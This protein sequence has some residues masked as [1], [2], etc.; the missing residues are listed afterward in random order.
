[1]RGLDAFIYYATAPIRLFGRSRAFRL[2]A[3]AAIILIV[4]FAGANWAINRIF[5]PDNAA[6]KAVANLPPPPPLPAVARA[7]QVIAPV[8]IP[9][10]LIQQSLDKTA[11]REFSGKGSESPL[12]GLLTNA[13]VGVVVN[14][15]TMAVTGKPNIL[16][17]TTPIT[18]SVHITGDFVARTANQAGGLVGSLGDKLGGD[19]GKFLNSDAGK[20]IGN[21]V[22]EIAKQTL[23]QTGNV[24]GQVIVQAQPA[25]AANWRLRAQSRRAGRSRRT[26]FD[27][28]GAAPASTCRRRSSR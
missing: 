11:P 24:R 25:L 10:A 12:S 4:S 26:S 2:T 22:G 7:S 28:G 9:L 20:N 14:R 5:P 27:A 23:N 18:S 1:M 3:A 15:G 17:V 6:K 19:I 21:V 13:D 16:T 8:T